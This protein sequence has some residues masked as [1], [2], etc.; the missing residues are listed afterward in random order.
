MILVDELQVWTA[1][2]IFRRGSSHLMTDGPIE[3]LH[4][5]A[6]RLGLRRE[7]FQDHAVHPH[8]DL[9]PRRRVDAIALGAVFVPAK[10]QARKRMAKVDALRAAAREET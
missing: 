7:W 2:G 3:E 10:E 4:D 5:F 1:R 6:Q 9:T 8:Y